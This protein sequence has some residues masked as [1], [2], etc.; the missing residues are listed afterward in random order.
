MELWFSNK[1]PADKNGA[2]MLGNRMALKK[3][4]W[5]LCEYQI[6]SFKN[7]K[8]PSRKNIYPLNYL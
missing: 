6:I 7:Q 4:F 1:S 3:Y 8:D 2:F 5:Y